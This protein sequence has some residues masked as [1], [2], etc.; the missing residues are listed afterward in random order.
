LATLVDFGNNCFNKILV[1][2][3]EEMILV[4][5]DTIPNMNNRK[6]LGFLGL[7]G[8]LGIQPALA[9]D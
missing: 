4:L 5:F 3:K 9:G 7:L 6:Y 1:G 8:F 2:K